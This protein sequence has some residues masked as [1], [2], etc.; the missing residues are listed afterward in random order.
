MKF[1]KTQ[2]NKERKMKNFEIVIVDEIYCDGSLLGLE[3]RIKEQIRKSWK[4]GSQKWGDG[5]KFKL[6][7]VT[8]VEEIDYGCY[9]SEDRNIIK[10]VLS[11]KMPEDD[12]A[13]IKRLT[14][15]AKAKIRRSN[16]K[17]TQEKKERTLLK[18]LKEK[19]KENG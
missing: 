9:G 12:L 18:N 16:A 1:T 11:K 17:T 19:Y 7:E 13:V 2:I 15:N 3:N 5:T 10:A 6:S 4:W 14:A 8:L